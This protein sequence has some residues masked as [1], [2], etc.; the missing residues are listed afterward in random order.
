M[1]TSIKI[2]EDIT[3]Q[4]SDHITRFKYGKYLKESEKYKKGR[5]KAS[6]WLSELSY[7]FIQKQKGFLLEFKQEIQE[8]KSKISSLNDCD[9]KKGLMDEL[10][11]IEDF[12]NERSN[13]K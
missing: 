1:D 12:I 13:C 6:S 7:Y 9:Y 10:N 2:L 4:C 11:L 5:I 8:Q 3:Y